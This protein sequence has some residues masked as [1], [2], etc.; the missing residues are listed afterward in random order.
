MSIADILTAIAPFGVKHVLVTG[1][2]PLLQ[3]QTPALIEALSAAGYTVSVETHGEVPIATIA[4]KAR[5]VMDIKT[6]ASGMNRGGFRVNLGDLRETDEIKFVIA[7]PNDYF[8]AREIIRA[9]ELPTREILLSPAMRAANCPTKFEG[10]N[11]T[12][13]AERILEDR[14]PV[15]LQVQLHKLLWG[16][17]RKGV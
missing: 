8:W 10:M 15:R 13:L 4:G 17:D 14:L 9:G 3:R 5:I 11:A 16:L 1:G 12:W 2:E 7:S 6:P